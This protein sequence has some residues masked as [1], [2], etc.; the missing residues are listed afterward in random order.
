MPWVFMSLAIVCE[1]I[2]TIALKMSSGLSVMMPSVVVVVG[3][4]SSFW[5]LAISLKSI[6][7]GTAYAIWSGVGTAIVT[8]AGVM[9]F[10]EPLGAVKLLSIGLII[11]GVVGLH[12]AES[13]LV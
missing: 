13:K 3:Y 7:I 5:F 8:I 4:A 9:I 10:K 2:G 11:L 1:V 12:W 6:G